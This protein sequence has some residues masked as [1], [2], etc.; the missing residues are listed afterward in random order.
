MCQLFPSY[1]LVASR[2][3]RGEREDR[4]TNLITSSLQRL[5]PSFRLGKF[6]RIGLLHTFVFRVCTHFAQRNNNV[7][8]L[9]FTLLCSLFFLPSIRN[10]D[11]KRRYFTFFW[12]ETG[13]QDNDF[14]ILIFLRLRYS[15][16]EFNSRKY[17]QH[18]T[19]WTTWNKN[20]E[21]WNSADSLLKRHFRHRSCCCRCLSS[22]I[23]P[24]CCLFSRNQGRVW[25]YNTIY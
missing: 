13:T 18:L 22:Q 3:L 17:H 14:L 9:L 11:V 7:P 12:G 15:P 10:H 2:R 23:P 21:F 25:I 5:I 24:C 19:N 16:W 20:D 4:K 6:L 1:S 8:P